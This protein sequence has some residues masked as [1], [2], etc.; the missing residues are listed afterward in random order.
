MPPAQRIPAPAVKARGG[1]R[2]LA[3]G[4]GGVLSG[5]C[6]KMMLMMERLPFPFVLAA[7]GG[8]LFSLGFAGEPVARG[9]PP[10]DGRSV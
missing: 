2:A 4:G 1:A 5:A 6:P 7:V 9:A 3:W 10:R 8:C